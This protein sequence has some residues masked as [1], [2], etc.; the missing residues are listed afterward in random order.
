MAKDEWWVCQG[1]GASVKLGQ[2]HICPIPISKPSDEVQAMRDVAAAIREN[3]E[4]LR[5]AYLGIASAINLL[6]AP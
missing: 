6:P 1:C 5:E 4:M 2:P 3:T